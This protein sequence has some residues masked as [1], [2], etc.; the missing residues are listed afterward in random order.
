MTGIAMLGGIVVVRT[1]IAF[2][3]NKDPRELAG[4]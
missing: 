2:F 1:V 4:K 3:L